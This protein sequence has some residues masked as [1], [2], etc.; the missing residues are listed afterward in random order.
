MLEANP[1]GF[2][3]FYTRFDLGGNNPNGSVMRIDQASS[4]AVML[5]QDVFA[6]ARQL[7]LIIDDWDTS[8]REIWPSV[9]KDYLYSLIDDSQVFAQAEETV[10]RG[11]FEHLR[12]WVRCAATAIDF[13][14]VLRGIAAREQGV[15]PR[16]NQ[17]VY[18]LDVENLVA[19][20]M[21]DD[22]GCLLYF[23]NQERC[24]AIYESRTDWVAT[25]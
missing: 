10:D 2:G 3:R 9:P 1:L 22:R 4:R 14:Q 24:Q 25:Y 6:H 19:F 7:I 23:G 20:C 21:Y 18:A 15:T 13:P 11:E 8:G 5:W 12:H 17:T 16:I